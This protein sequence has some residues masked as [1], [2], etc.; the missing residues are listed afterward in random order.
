M[1]KR[2]SIKPDYGKMSGK[3]SNKS[4]AASK[5]HSSDSE[6]SECAE[7]IAYDQNCT[8]CKS[9]VEIIKELS[10]RV[11]SME[12]KL[13]AMAQ[14]EA[15]PPPTDQTALDAMS[16]KMKEL[17]ERLEERTNRQLR[18]TLVFRNVPEVEE[19]KKWSTTKALL[20]SKISQVLDDVDENEAMQM[21]D[22]CHRGGKKPSDGEE[23]PS[24]PRPIYAAMLYWED[25]ERLTRE[26]RSSSVGFY[27][28]Y[29][30]GP[31]T[32]VRRNEALKRR[33]ELKAAG[34]I[35]HGYVAFPARLIG[36]KANGQYH[37][38]EDFSDMEVNLLP[39][40]R[41]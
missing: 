23:R 36:K 27:I 1:T 10:G 12:K 26:A 18:K 13:E 25:C 11:L 35:D 2:H 7:D 8:S 4:A 24:R 9:L 14:N 33:K 16:T 21:I 22:R 40:K 20:A 3:K 5:C 15:P 38:I 34:V 17:E 41:K 29:K 19:D 31:R 32:T 30:Y 6:N 39:R 28:D 37:E